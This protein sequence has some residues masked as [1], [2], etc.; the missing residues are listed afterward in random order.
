MRILVPAVASLAFLAL[1]YAPECN[2]STGRPEPRPDRT[3]K[4]EVVEMHKGEMSKPTNP[5]PPPDLSPS[6]ATT[7]ERASTPP[8]APE[9]GT[10]VLVLSA[11]AVALFQRRRSA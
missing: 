4:T 6:D 5:T 3:A 8:E 7:Q 9:P 2:A 10:L 1:S 11:G